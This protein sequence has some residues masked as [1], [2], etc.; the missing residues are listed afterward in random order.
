[1][2]QIL[3]LEYKQAIIEAAKKE[4]LQNG[5]RDASMR[6][7]ANNANMTVGNLY[8]Y[9]KNKEEI[10]SEVLGPTLSKLQD[11]LKSIKSSNLSTETRVFNVKPDVGKLKKAFNSTIDKVIDI[12][13]SNCQ[14]FNIV[15]F[16]QTYS[17]NFI[18]WFM[19]VVDGLISD[20]FL[21]GNLNSDKTTL[22]KSY[23]EAFLQG[24]R[25]LFKNYDGDIDDLKSLLKT[26]VN[27]FIYMLNADLT[28]LDS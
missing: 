15:L 10:Y 1:M 12:Y 14:E 8:R 25:S 5:Y 28:N 26:Y 22:S 17:N 3:K 4:I 6:T 16:D 21:L 2:A 7:I 9:F 18:N 24:V 23:S 19:D 13:T 11:A 20:N 27:S